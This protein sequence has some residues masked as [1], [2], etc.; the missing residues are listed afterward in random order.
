VH[1]LQTDV[2]DESV[3]VNA[4]AVPPVISQLSVE[5]CPGVMVPGDAVRLSVNG[6]VTV[7]VCGPA[8]PAGPVAV[9]ENVVVAFTG[10]LADPEVGGGPVSSGR[11]IAGVIVTDVAFVVAQVRVVVCPVLSSMGAAVNWVICGGTLDATC[12]VA[13]CGELVPPG[14]DAVAV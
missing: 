14:P 2:P 5:L 6:T 9:R 3:R 10:T 4:V 8:V 12:T 1:G 13:V 11:G 7:T